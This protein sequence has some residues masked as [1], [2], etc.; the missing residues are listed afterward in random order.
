MSELLGLLKDF[1][2]LPVPDRKKVLLIIFDKYAGKKDLFSFLEDVSEK[3]SSSELRSMAREKHD[4]LEKKYK[5]QKKADKIVTPEIAKG[6]DQEKI[7]LLIKKELETGTREKIVAALNIII[8]R[9]LYH[10]FP[11]L[12]AYIQKCKDPYI[13]ATI[14][15]VIS[16]FASND[17]KCNKGNAKK[18]FLAYINSS[19]SRVRANSL[20]ALGSI[21]ITEEDIPLLEKL[22]GDEDNRVKAN[23]A[24]IIGNIDYTR[25]DGFLKRLVNSSKENER[26]SA[27]WLCFKFIIKGGLALLWDSLEKEESDELLLKISI[28]ILKS[29]DENRKKFLEW[30]KKTSRKILITNI[31]HNGITSVQDEVEKKL[32]SDILEDIETTALQPVIESED[33][34]LRIPKSIENFFEEFNSIKDAKIR[35][36]A[37]TA[38]SVRNKQEI[39]DFIEMATLDDDAKVRVC[40]RKL[41]EKYENGEEF[42]G[43]PVYFIQELEE[44]GT[45]IP[46]ETYFIE[47]SDVMEEDAVVES[48]TSEIEEKSDSSDPEVEKVDSVSSEESAEISKLREIINNKEEK[49]RDTKKTLRKNKVSLITA[50]SNSGR[51]FQEKIVLLVSLGYNESEFYDAFRNNNQNYIDKYI[52]GMNTIEELREKYS[53]FFDYC[54]NN[55]VVDDE[56]RA[57][58]EKIK[59]P[60]FSKMIKEEVEALYKDD[61]GLK[62]E[63]KDFIQQKK[64]E[65]F[66]VDSYFSK[67]ELPL[68]RVKSEYKLLKSRILKLEKFGLLIEHSEIR[69]FEDKIA[70]IKSL[71]KNVNEVE[72]IAKMIEDATQRVN[73]LRNNIIE[74]VEKWKQTGYIMDVFSGKLAGD[75]VN[76][77]DIYV[78]YKKKVF[79]IE[80]TL[81]SLEEVQNEENASIISGLRK[82]L[83]DLSNYE[84]NIKN[85]EE[86]LN[87][88]GYKGKYAKEAVEAAIEKFKADGFNADR[89]NE[90]I[91]EK[92]DII[93]VVVD[94]YEKDII[95]IRNITEY[96]ELHVKAGKI[97]DDNN[98][99]VSLLEKLK[100]LEN[101]DNLIEQIEE[102]LL[103]N[104]ISVKDWDMGFEQ[105]A[106][107]IE[108]SN[109]VV[110]DELEPGLVVEAETKVQE[111]NP[112][113]KFIDNLK[114]KLSET[115]IA[116]AAIGLIFLLVLGSGGY[117]IYNYLFNPM[118]IVY[119]GI[120]L[121]KKGEFASALEKFKL[122]KEKDSKLDGINRYM[123]GT[124]IEMS[125]KE[126][127]T[128][129]QIELLLKAYPYS[130]NGIYRNIFK[131]VGLS[132]KEE[133]TAKP[134]GRRKLSGGGRNKRGRSK[135]KSAVA[136]EINID[137]LLAE[138]YYEEM[139]TL[140][141]DREKLINLKNA[142]KRNPKSEKVIDALCEL[143]IKMINSLAKEAEEAKKNKKPVRNFNTKIKAILKN[144]VEF[145]SS[146]HKVKLAELTVYN[147][148]G[149][150]ERTLTVAE[151]IY[152]NKKYNNSIAKTVTAAILKLG[153]KLKN[154]DEKISFFQKNIK[155][156]SDNKYIAIELKILYKEKAGNSN[157]IEDSLYYYKEVQKLF[158]GDKEVNE[159]LVKAYIGRAKTS[160]KLGRRQ[161]LLEKARDIV[162]DFP[163]LLEQ[164]A[165][166][167]QMKADNC[168]EADE[169]KK[170]TAL[171]KEALTE[172][173][174]KKPE[175][176]FARKRLAMVYYNNALLDKDYHE[177]RLLLKE[178]LKYEKENPMIFYELGMACV[179]IDLT[180]KA[181]E[182]FIKATKLKKDYS[183]A[184]RNLALICEKDKKYEEAIRWW[185]QYR[186]FVKDEDTLKQVKQRIRQLL[187]LRKLND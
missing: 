73:N 171:E 59:N 103:L 65:E 43:K 93:K 125:N 179:K 96:S 6:N 87:D 186:K 30:L 88:H 169:K 7:T 161:L 69:I 116:Y 121:Y 31:L 135:N 105:S 97:S 49:I 128:Y 134:K 130:D 182:N 48:K 72:S 77:N 155:F 52:D 115:K 5:I 176:Q 42:E 23:A 56:V 20:E 162:G 24:F 78:D 119:Q 163:P 68:F 167:Y 133:K 39:W 50:L 184:Y 17:K 139:L 70:K 166:L 113:T 101:L 187:K 129:K 82:E 38:I 4:F 158:P 85:A 177:R 8:S 157:K 21:G 156:D 132:G 124:Y 18:I 80:N 138:K 16:F 53:G 19:A 152:K 63:F 172:F 98:E 117:F 143:G 3:D 15:R 120:E 127:N 46:E 67:L 112:K 2:K 154:S 61:E 60:I 75:I 185:K 141:T 136:G 148:D 86:I 150:Y 34:T 84:M 54:E 175:N 76:L 89:L 118:S 51:D 108:E 14:I 13:Q 32:L 145:A 26:V 71:L 33:G 58:V 94:E 12:V 27:Y 131:E 90:A 140:D 95:I 170:W 149:N 151:K 180:I 104:N 178:A 153:S 181:K 160:K 122:A 1:Y 146:S 173:I 11:Y 107:K 62:D 144:L 126:P 142:A 10:F 40:A 102:I 174:K 9:K 109:D 79:N 22:L 28:Y 123:C 81:K 111:S 35:N 45:K 25:V 44:F 41:L 114:T 147:L 137:H 47:K 168:E 36:F 99:L 106:V 57:L 91:N 110:D 183:L 29:G 64:D 37:L 164:F 66:L 92:E 83:Y 159:E 165:R 74:C 55:D 100:K